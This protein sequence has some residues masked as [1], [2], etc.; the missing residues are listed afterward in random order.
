MNS[1][2]IE[3]RRRSDGQ[4]LG[5]ME[6]SGE[7]FVAVDLLGRERTEVVDWLTAEETLDELGIGYL[8]DPYEL[9]LDGQ[10]L[11][12]RLAQVSVEGIVVKHD[13][14]GANAIDAPQQFHELGFPAPATLRATRR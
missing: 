8:A 10:W 3:H 2:W 5:W 13:D 12:V 6:P 4:L 7:G 14:W 11:P 1:N 9:R